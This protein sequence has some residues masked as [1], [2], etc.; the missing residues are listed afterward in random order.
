MNFLAPKTPHRGRPA[1]TVKTLTDF[2]L[3]R[4]RKEEERRGKNLLP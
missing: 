3:Y 4:A 2:T 1:F